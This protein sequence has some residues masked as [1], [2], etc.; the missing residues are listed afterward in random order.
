ML[1]F[2]RSADAPSNFWAKIIA[3]ARVMILD[4]SGRD[5]FHSSHVVRVTSKNKHNAPT[6]MARIFGIFSTVTTP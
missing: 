1:A 6:V 5:D 4:K 2:S 3:S